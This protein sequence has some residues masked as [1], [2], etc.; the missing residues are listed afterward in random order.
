MTGSE[1]LAGNYSEVRWQ[2]IAAMCI[3]L[4]NLGMLKVFTVFTV[5]VLLIEFNNQERTVYE[6]FRHWKNRD[7]FGLDA[8]VC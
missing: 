5:V 6:A 2:I 3:Q 4:S 8:N 7:P 1:R